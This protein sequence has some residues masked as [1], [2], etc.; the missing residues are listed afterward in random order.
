MVSTYL[1]LPEVFLTTIPYKEYFA[2]HSEDHM[3][4]RLNAVREGEATTLGVI[5]TISCDL[6]SS[7]DSDD[8][9]SDYGG[10]PG[11]C[12]VPN[13]PDY[14]PGPGV[15][16]QFFDA[17]RW[18]ISQES[19]FLPNKGGYLVSLMNECYQHVFLQGCQCPWH[20]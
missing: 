1:N 20:T 5:D 19:L 12:D 7:D 16:R 6:G 9:D 13:L 2:G 10:H 18:Y 14:C 15:V 4:H 17:F 11:G 3:A 8:S